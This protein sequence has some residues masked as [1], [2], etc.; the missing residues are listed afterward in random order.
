MTKPVA[1]MT[2]LCCSSAVTIAAIGIYAALRAIFCDYSQGLRFEMLDQ[3]YLAAAHS[4]TEQYR[5]A[6]KKERER[7]VQIARRLIDKSDLIHAALQ[8][9]ARLTPAQATALAVKITHS[10]KSILEID[11]L[12]QPQASKPLPLKTGG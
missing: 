1:I 11:R 5:D 6:G 8:K 9:T 2:Y 3:S 12:A 10:A 7:I 4:L